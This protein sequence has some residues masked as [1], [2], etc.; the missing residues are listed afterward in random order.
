MLTVLS[1]QVALQELQIGDVK[2]TVGYE[3]SLA[4][5]EEIIGNL[6]Y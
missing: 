4:E 2:A 5:L 3:K 6:L 1:A